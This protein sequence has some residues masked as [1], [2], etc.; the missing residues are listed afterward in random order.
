MKVLQINKLYYPH[1]GGV[2]KH[3]QDVAEAIHD[4]VDVKVLVANSERKTVREE[5]NGIPVTRVPSWGVLQSAPVAP[6]FYTAIRNSD[7]DIF[8]LHFPN[9]VG[10]IA[11]LAAGAP[12]KLVVT[13]HADVV[14][15]RT[16]RHFYGPVIKRLLDR[17]D[18]IMASSPNLIE[19]SPWLTDV[20][21]KCRVIPFGIDLTPWRMNDYTA[22][23]TAD[24]RA[25]FGF[26]I[27]LFVGRLI[28][29][30]GLDFLI[31]ALTDVDA[32]LIIV[33]QGVLEEELL[34][35]AAELGVADRVHF[36]GSVSA[37]DL[38]AYYHACDV[39][40]LPSVAE[41]EAFGF[42]Q[43]EAHAC[44]KPVVSTN[45]PTGVPYANLDNVT[46]LIVPP[47]NPEALAVALN[48]LLSDRPFRY[49]LGE[50]AKLRVETEF[51][52]EAM[53]REIIKA[54]REILAE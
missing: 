15:Q 3:V 33:G 39:F 36:V 43:L 20:R 19:L 47:K 54:Y 32:N 46:G 51:S 30:K 13:Y 35:L 23:K 12:G 28:Y 50:Q 6:G 5:I 53:G 18:M 29:Y 8:H 49:Q 38:P 40:T 25:R 21:R 2:E 34:R 44:G 37:E 16:L 26:P 7:A 31:R 41:S 45:L 27:I 4:E 22:A 52:L 42:V 11:Y 24:I 14:R 1:I 48:R 10:E 9:P 17:A